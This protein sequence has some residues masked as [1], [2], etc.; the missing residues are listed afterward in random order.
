MNKVLTGI[1]ALFIVGAATLPVAASAAEQGGVTKA[2]STDLSS[3]RHWRHH[4]HYGYRYWRPRHYGYRYYGPRR[5]YGYYGYGY[6][7]RYGYGY[8]PYYRP[9]FAVGVGPLGVRVF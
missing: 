8:R 2:Q 5:H 6:P 3:Q 4:R 9:G 7:Y 1:A